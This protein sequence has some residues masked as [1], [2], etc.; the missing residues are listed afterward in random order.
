MT[1]RTVSRREPFAFLFWSVVLGQDEEDATLDTAEGGS[2]QSTQA[3]SSPN[4]GGGEG[5]MSGGLTSAG[6]A[7]ARSQSAPTGVGAGVSSD[8]AG[9]FFESEE[10]LAGVSRTAALR[11]RRKAKQVTA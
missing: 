8:L 9:A 1:T 10:A 3:A 7:A 2:S 4:G 5:G 11:L 6:G